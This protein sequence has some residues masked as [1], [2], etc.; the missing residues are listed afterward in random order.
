MQVF[1]QI[2]KKKIN[3]SRQHFTICMK[4]ASLLS[5]TLSYIQDKPTI[6]SPSPS[7]NGNRVAGNPTAM[8]FVPITGRTT[9]APSGNSVMRKF[10]TDR[11]SHSFQ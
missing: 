4:N 9:A 6:A 2:D 11:V 1:D 7:L 3:Q 5:L 10:V 8:R